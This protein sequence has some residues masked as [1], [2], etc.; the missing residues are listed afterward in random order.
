MINLYDNQ[1]YLIRQLSDIDHVDI[2][3]V[4]EFKKSL[5]LFVKSKII[6]TQIRELFDNDLLIYNYAFICVF[7]GNDFLPHLSYISL[8][9]TGLDILIQ[10]IIELI[11]EYEGVDMDKL[12]ANHLLLYF[13]KDNNQYKLNNE[14]L[15]KLFEKLSKIEDTEFRKYYDKFM[16]L[17]IIDKNI[18]KIHKNMS[19]ELFDKHYQHLA[20]IERKP[21]I[22]FSALNSWRINYY[23]LLF[24]NEST[25]DIQNKVCYNYIEGL[26][27]YIN[28]YFNQKLPTNGWF[29][30]YNY[31]PT[32]LD[33]YFH[34][35]MN[36]NYNN[37]FDKHPYSQYELNKNDSLIQLMYILPYGSKDIINKL[38]KNKYDILYDKHHLGLYF[39][40]KYELITYFKKNYWACCPNIPF[41]PITELRKFITPV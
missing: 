3:N 38:T 5:S 19:I 6:N 39:P 14:V 28:Y 8:D 31:S 20:I 11:N 34:S 25:H 12:Y 16:K 35:S 4:N 17:K 40:H 24:P 27:W 30:N 23:N 2:F 36:M 26:I 9:N 10:Y 29:Y 22:I 18:L 13:D 37:I 15:N 33:L 41:L 7:L 32:V 1:I 21:M